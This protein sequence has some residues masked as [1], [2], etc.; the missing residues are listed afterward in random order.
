ML[1]NLSHIGIA[2]QSIGRASEFFGKT[3]KLGEP[4]IIE[5]P[6]QKVRVAIFRFAGFQIELLEPMGQD[7]TIA[8]FLEKR[9]EGIHHLCFNVENIENALSE[10]KMA[11]VNLIDEKPRLGATG[12][13]IAFVSPKSTYGVLIELREPKIK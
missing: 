11:G 10:L 4:E 3:L 1:K 13:K 5:V 2:V 6:D 9:G 8:K 12:N 7:S